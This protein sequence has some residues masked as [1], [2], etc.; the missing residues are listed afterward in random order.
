MRLL[1][2]GRCC[3][4]DGSKSRPYAPRSVPARQVV[5][6][7]EGSQGPSKATRSKESRNG[8]RSGAGPGGR[9][10]RSV[11]RLGVRAPLSLGF[12]VRF[13]SVD[14]ARRPSLRVLD[15]ELL[16][17]GG[18]PWAEWHWQRC[19]HDLLAAAPSPFGLRASRRDLVPAKVGPIC[20]WPSL[21]SL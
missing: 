20:T 1:L 15:V 13:R 3:S 5:E 16:Q 19:M 7:C 6:A 9:R 21:E 8:F 2:H 11:G 10:G 17:D 18:S 12:S 14:T 4:S